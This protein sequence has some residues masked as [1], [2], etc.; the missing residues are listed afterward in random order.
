VTSTVA[1]KPEK[2]DPA[3][4]GDW[5]IWSTDFSDPMEQWMNSVARTF[6]TISIHNYQKSECRIRALTRSVSGFSLVRCA[7]M[8][9]RARI[10]RTAA[11]IRTDQRDDYLLYLPLCGEQEIEQRSRKA[12]CSPEAWT[13]S[14]IGEPVV[15]TKLG[16]DDTIYLSIPRSFVDQRVVNGGDICARTVGARDGLPRLV[17][18][19]LLSLHRES[20]RLST[21]EF[22]CAVRAVADLLVLALV[23]Q[24]DLTSSDRSIR[25][26]NLARAKRIIGERFAEPGLSPADIARQC[27]FSL[28]H[29]HDL[30]LDERRTV[31]EY[32]QAQR[33]RAAHTLLQSAP[34][35]PAP[36]TEVCLACGFATPSQFSTVFKKAFG[37]SP[38]DVLQR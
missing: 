18:D 16:R 28:R 38:R 23:G 30:F 13:I 10:E 3:S 20:S 19:T 32:L 24:A 7:T 34:A 37:V 33:L 6:C 12:T 31:C 5:G 22:L 35:G 9:G 27:G 8:S 14:S 36:I 21:V 25:A 1:M 11:M 2:A 4:P 26:C 15:Q 17:T 29:L